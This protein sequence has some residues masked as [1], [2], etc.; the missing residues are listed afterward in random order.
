MNGLRV[1]EETWLTPIGIVRPS[2]LRS[3]RAPD[4]ANNAAWTA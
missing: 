4:L 1:G 3:S 2:T